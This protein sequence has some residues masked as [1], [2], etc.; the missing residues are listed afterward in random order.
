MAVIKL[1]PDGTQLASFFNTSTYPTLVYPNAVALDSDN[2]LYIADSWEACIIKLDPQGHQTAV[3]S[4]SSPALLYPNG[5]FIDPSFGVYVTDTVNQRIIYFSCNGDILAIYSGGLAYPKSVW[6]ADGT[7][8]TADSDNNQITLFAV[9]ATSYDA[10][11]CPQLQTSNAASSTGADGPSTSPVT[12]FFTYSTTSTNQYPKICVSGALSCMVEDDGTYICS[13]VEAGI[14]TFYPSSSLPSIVTPLLS[15][16]IPLPTSCAGYSPDNVLPLTSNGLSVQV[17]QDCFVLSTSKG[18][19][20]VEPETVVG[21]V[22]WTYS[23]SATGVPLCP[24][25]VAGSNPTPGTS[26]SFVYTTATGGADP[27]ISC[28]AGTLSCTAYGAD[29]YTCQSMLNGQ[30]FVAV[31]GSSNTSSSALYLTTCGGHGDQYLPVTYEGL[32]V[33]V[34]SGSD[35]QCLNV[36]ADADG[37]IRI[38][39]TGIAALAD[40]FNFTFTY[41]AGSVDPATACAALLPGLGL[42]PSSSPAGS[43]SSSSGSGTTVTPP[44]AFCLLIG[45]PSYAVQFGGLLNTTI[46]PQLVQPTDGNLLPY[47]MYAYTAISASG[48]R[49]YTNL[50]TNTVVSSSILSLDPGFVG[51][52]N[53]IYYG[54]T[55]AAT[56]W[57]GIAFVMDMEVPIAGQP[58]SGEG[59]Y[60]VWWQPDQ[61][62]YLEETNSDSGETRP[63]SSSLTVVPYSGIA[64]TCG[65]S[66]VEGQ[67]N[68]SSSST[69][70]T[71][72][73]SAGT[74]AIS[75][76]TGHFSSSSPAAP[77]YNQ[78]TQVVALY[79]ISNSAFGS[80]IQNVFVD[81]AGHVLVTDGSS[82]GLVVL[83]AVTSST[84]GSQLFF[85]SLYGASGVVVDSQGHIY[86]GLTGGGVVVLAGINSVTPSPGTVLLRFAN[87]TRNLYFPDVALDPSG[88]VYVS[89]IDTSTVRVYSA[90]NSSTP[91]QLLLSYNQSFYDPC[92]LATDNLGYVY[93][94]DYYKP[95]PAL[96]TIWVLNGLTAGQAV[97]S[98]LF[99]F[100]GGFST[101]AVTVDCS[102]TMYVADIYFH[103]IVVLASIHTSTPGAIITAFSDSTRPFLPYAVAVDA[104]GRIYI[105]DDTSKAVRVVAGLPQNESNSCSTASQYRGSSSSTGVASTHSS[106]NVATSTTSSQGSTS[107]GASA[108]PQNS[109]SA[110]SSI[111]S[112]AQQSNPAS[113]STSSI[114][115]VSLSATAQSSSTA[116]AAGSTGFPAGSI[117]IQ[118]YVELLSLANLTAAAIELRRDIAYNIAEE[119]ISTLAF[120]LQ[121]VEITSIAGTPLSSSSARRLLQ[122]GSGSN[123]SSSSNATGVT[124]VLLGSISSVAS[125]SASTAASVFA[126][127][128][129]QGVLAAPY[130]N[131]TIP[132]QTVTTVPLTV[133]STGVGSSNAATPTVS[134]CMAGPL[135][136]LTLLALALLW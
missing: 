132:A 97:G 91:G 88:A 23:T 3:F 99:T 15:S 106:S 16:P 108:A 103:R 34:G 128:A 4:T 131:A 10:S 2:N 52:T 63:T 76:P 45:G 19:V 37:T 55:W 65:S 32:S 73:S 129:A 44:F 75:A 24:A 29:E 107:V 118:F 38:T 79:N 110:T 27:S 54:S 114:P 53:Y 133:S 36:W 104:A 39:A 120:V 1:A 8:Y 115:S 74:G 22:N 7:I 117:S 68:I 49:V 135:L 80:D 30:Q 134:S 90:F 61:G 71:F 57:N 130:S 18:F 83:S 109:S 62:H 127:A 67:P 9:A 59:N 42:P 31:N 46:T 50:T 60:A 136:A 78:S 26:V 58:R 111:S 11:T 20:Q 25:P 77:S 96:S 41:A 122:T 28:G 87:Q 33:A 93:V 13:S 51:A 86:L 5:V 123:S 92:G 21:T 85:F 112:A 98:T 72:Q 84:P 113:S 70:G 6:V 125:V 40:A 119:I 102:G 101:E 17:G 12:L 82:H 66:V 43:S 126:A 69:G 81:A 89:D 48:V 47:A 35:V 105:G 121:Y 95:I 116:A 14:H 64:V 124:F 100:Q 56:D 94:A